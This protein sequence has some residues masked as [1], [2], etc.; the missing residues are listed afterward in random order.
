[1]MSKKALVLAS[2][3][4]INFSI[5]LEDTLVKGLKT[6][7]FLSFPIYFHFKKQPNFP[8]HKWAQRTFIYT[9]MFIVKLFIIN[10]WK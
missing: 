4:S 1:M 9:N 3:G 5:F 2:G 10:D 6:D 8:S 7:F